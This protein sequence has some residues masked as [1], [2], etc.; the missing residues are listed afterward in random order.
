[1]DPQQASPTGPAAANNGRTSHRRRQ[2][3]VKM[4]FALEFKSCLSHRGHQRKTSRSEVQRNDAFVQRL[5]L[6]PEWSRALVGLARGPYRPSSSW[7]RRRST[8]SSPPRYEAV[9]GRAYGSLTAWSCQLRHP[10]SPS[11]NRSCPTLASSTRR[12]GGDSDGSSR[13]A[14]KR[15]GHIPLPSAGTP[16]PWLRWASGRER[17]SRTTCIPPLT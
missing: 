6:T 10:E 11:P 15:V 1:L 2:A 4:C 14:A 17:R 8:A 3:G 5:A 16:P 13:L 7:A 9:Q 12:P